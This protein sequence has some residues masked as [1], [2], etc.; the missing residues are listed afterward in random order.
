MLHV[1]LDQFIAAVEVLRRP[2]LAGKPVIVGGRG[3]PTERAVVSTAS[4]EARA[5]G[6]G[7]G[8]PLRIAARN[9]PDAVILPVDQEAYLQASGE[10]MG[11]L[12]SRPGAVVQVLGWDEAFVGVQ[13]S[14]PEA[15]AGQLQQ[16]VLEAT[17]LHCSVGIGDTLVRAKVATTFGKPAG[18]FRL[19]AENWLDVMGNRPT[20]DLWGV[21]TK[22]SRRLAT[23][24]ITTVAELA[25]VDPDFLVPEF[26]PKMGPWYAQLGRGDG[27]SVVDDT[28]WVAR[29]HSRET[30]FQHDLTE[31]AQVDEAVRELVAAVLDDVAAEG[32][33]VVGLTLKV[34]Y[35]P[36]NT[37]T[38]ARRIPE[39]ADPEE[40][41]TRALDLRGKIE[42]D[43][44]IRLL[45]LRAEMT[46]PDESRQ[47]H[48][49][50]RSGW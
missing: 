47:G 12:R 23:L 50:T 19:T 15:Y 10:V 27:S 49:P 18:V 22:V 11:V 43:R 4:Y 42:P 5:F 9:V 28:P 13:S 21:G 46:M 33:P 14:D 17:R 39:T 1:D 35:A 34:R 48:T 37:K 31:P 40:V 20:I 16:A 30:T 8:M 44:P 6:V 41:L 25:A 36:F 2:E 38:F 45:G 3:D 26:G 29:G 24:G 7:S 32:R